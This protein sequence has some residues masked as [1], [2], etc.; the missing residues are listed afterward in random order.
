MAALYCRVTIFGFFNAKFLKTSFFSSVFG[1]LTY[2]YNN[3]KS[4]DICKFLNTESLQLRLERSHQCWY[5]HVT[6]MS[7]ERITAKK[8]LYSTPIGR[9][10]RGRLRARWQNYVKDFSWSRLSIPAKHLSFVAVDRDAW[11]LQL[12]LLPPRPPKDKRI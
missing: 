4:E 3:V 12:K 8:L 2:F 10:P 9:R 6:Q 5:A 11:R 1:S 7:P